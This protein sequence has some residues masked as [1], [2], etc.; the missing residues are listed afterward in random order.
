MCFGSTGLTEKSRKSRWYAFSIHSLNT[1]KTDFTDT[2]PRWFPCFLAEFLS[3]D[4]FSFDLSAEQQL[5][6]F[7]FRTW[8][9]LIADDTQLTGTFRFNRARVWPHPRHPAHSFHCWLVW[10][11]NLCIFH[12]ARNI[13]GKMFTFTGQSFYLFQL[14]IKFESNTSCFFALCDKMH[15]FSSIKLAVRSWSQPTDCSGHN[16]LETTLNNINWK[17]NSFKKQE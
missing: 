11:W 1:V 8:W 12:P 16:Q 13:S 14:N 10:S 9:T 4:S 3:F 2:I 6:V 15:F 5:C 7:C 17:I